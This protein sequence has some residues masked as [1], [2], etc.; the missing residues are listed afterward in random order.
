[1]LKRL[2]SYYWVHFPSFDQDLSLTAPWPTAGKQHRS[3]AESSL[4]PH[5]RVARSGRRRIVPL[6]TRKDPSWSVLSHM[7]GKAAFSF[8]R[9]L[10]PHLRAKGAS[11]EGGVT[12]CSFKD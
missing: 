1:M 7:P 12:S 10:G 5:G 3:V 9:S 2:H 8:P 6:V 11:T 4:A